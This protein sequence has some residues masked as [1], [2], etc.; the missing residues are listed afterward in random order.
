MFNP[1]SDHISNHMSKYMSK[2]MSKHMS[3]PMSEYVLTT[4]PS[5]ISSTLWGFA[6]ASVCL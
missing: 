5:P 3:N 4:C 2:H 6:T 1:M